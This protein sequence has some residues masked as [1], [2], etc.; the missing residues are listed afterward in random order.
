MRDTL[1][2]MGFFFIPIFIFRGEGWI[3]NTLVDVVVLLP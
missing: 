2:F 1:T 3:G